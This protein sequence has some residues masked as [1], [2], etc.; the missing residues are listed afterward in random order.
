MRRVQGDFSHKALNSTFTPMK[1][2]ADRILEWYDSLWQ[3]ELPLPSD[4]RALKPFD[5]PTVR[6]SAQRFYKKYY[7]DHRPRTVLIG[8]NPGRLG[9]GTTGIPFT[10]PK[11][12]VSDCG[13]DYDGPIS[14][15]PSSVFVY[16]VIRAYGGP[17]PFFGDFYITSVCPIGFVALNQ[18]NR[19]VNFNYYDR[20][21]VAQSLADFVDASMRT[22]L[23]WGL[24]SE[25]GVSLGKGKNQA[26][27]ERWNKAYH[28]FSRVDA[29]EHPRYVMQYKSREMERYV[30]L[31]LDILTEIRPK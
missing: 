28:W 24:S 5:D 13:I 20:P 15:E 19:W 7:S 12:L 6:A 18:R 17:E 29:L 22:Q 26:Y 1:T 25:V 2:T 23:S 4:V 11:R 31:Y 8:I 3:T 27:L 30:Q 21:E 16:E 9:A 14:H 10:D